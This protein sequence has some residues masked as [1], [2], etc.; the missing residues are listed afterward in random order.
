MSEYSP[1]IRTRLAPRKTT[2]GRG[3]R[4]DEP[5]TRVR[6]NEDRSG[7][8]ATVGEEGRSRTH[9]SCWSRGRSGARPWGH[10]LRPWRRLAWPRRA[11]IGARAPPLAPLCP[12]PA[13]SAPGVV[14]PGHGE[15]RPRRTARR[16]SARALGPALPSPREL[17][18]HRRR[19]LGAPRGGSP[20]QRAFGLWRR[21]RG[22]ALLRAASGLLL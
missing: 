5:H 12:A 10:E 11:A 21:R 15:L 3:P 14:E 4:W 13:S 9:W 20:G 2:D 6:R 1:K 7:C 18:P 19:R 16:S 17:Q 8:F 22:P